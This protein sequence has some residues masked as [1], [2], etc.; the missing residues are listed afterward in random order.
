MYFIY[1]YIYI[2][3]YVFIHMY[4]PADVSIGMFGCPWKFSDLFW[5]RVLPEVIRTEL[6]VLLMIEN[7]MSCRISI[8][9]RMSFGLV[10]LIPSRALQGHV[11]S[12][13]E[14]TYAFLEG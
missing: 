8:I 1:I 4:V 6:W 10:L 7:M 2:C 14:W 11:L 3:I 5:C 13:C 9:N 12:F